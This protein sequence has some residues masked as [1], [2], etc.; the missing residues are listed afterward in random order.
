MDWETIAVPANVKNGLKL[1]AEK[2]H[3]SV[4][5]LVQWIFANAGIKELSDQ[6]LD[7]EMEV[8]AK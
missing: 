4:A 7:K 5:N 8:I 2:Q 3:R 6:E 1:E